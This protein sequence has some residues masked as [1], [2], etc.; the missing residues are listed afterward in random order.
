MDKPDALAIFQWIAFS[1]RPLSLEELAEAA[2]VRP[3]NDPVDPDDRLTNVLEVVRICQSL[4]SLFTDSVDENKV[5]KVQFAHFSVQEYLI[6]KRAGPFSLSTTASQN[7]VAGCCISYLLQF[8]DGRDTQDP[9]IEYPLL[10]YT[11]N[12]W[13]HHVQQANDGDSVLKNLLYNLFSPRFQPVHSLFERAHALSNPS[14]ELLRPTRSGKLYISS[15]LGLPYV[16]QRLIEEGCEIDATYNTLGEDI[17]FPP[18]VTALEA[19]ALNWHE[20]VVDILLSYSADPNVRTESIVQT[21]LER[22]RYLH[23]KDKSCTTRICIRL[24][25]AGAGLGAVINCMMPSSLA[26]AS[27]CGLTDVVKDLLNRGIDPNAGSDDY[28]SVALQWAAAKGEHEIVLM[29]LEAGSDIDAPGDS[30]YDSALGAAARFHHHAILEL[31]LDR[32]ASPQGGSAEPYYGDA[33]PNAA[34]SGNIRGWNRLIQAGVNPDVLGNGLGGLLRIVLTGLPI[35]ISE[36]RGAHE[37]IAWKLLEMGADPNAQNGAGDLEAKPNHSDP[38]HNRY[39]DWSYLTPLCLAVQAGNLQIVRWLIDAGADVNHC[40]GISP[41]ALYE[42]VSMRN[43]ELTNYLLDSGADPNLGYTQGGR[44]TPLAVAVNK[45]DVNCVKL[46]V[47]AGVNVNV[48]SSHGTVLIQAIVSSTELEVVQAIIDAGADLNVSVKMYGTALQRAI[49]YGQV[50]L[51][52][53]LIDA[54][55]DVNLA[56][57]TDNS[58][59]TPLEIAFHEIRGRW[60]RNYVQEQSI[61]IVKLLIE[62]GAQVTDRARELHAEIQLS[63]K[64]DRVEHEP[65]ITQQ[66][67]DTSMT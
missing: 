14:L 33:L 21:L 11:S 48:L 61:A 39:K 45:G 13:I 22:H 9:N 28:P 16:T 27:L 53:T 20:P 65:I 57:L 17:L 31:L 41:T 37:S 12:N 64:E 1:K 50:D 55:A 52:Q 62:R 51:V 32:G 34:Y 29:L 35:T 25:D 54:G 26:N 2:I 19:A 67:L 36:S 59:G 46:L 40:D 4:V 7:F 56:N 30:R 18:F 44:L 10:S 3:T 6:S 38:R 49:S 47:K 23:R 43:V 5:T 58:L 66:G 24:L 8:G 15:L 63:W 42:A 60:N